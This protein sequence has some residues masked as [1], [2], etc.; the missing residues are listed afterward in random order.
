MDLNEDGYKKLSKKIEDLN[1][2][3]FNVVA[4]A[5]QE[6][7]ND[8][9]FTNRSSNDS[10]K[11]TKDVNLQLKELEHKIEIVNSAIVTSTWL[12]YYV[13]KMLH[14]NSTQ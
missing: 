7:V 12:E 14:T 9:G 8:Y 13:N 6:N 5:K 1:T 3:L 4:S 11:S 2:K 10:I